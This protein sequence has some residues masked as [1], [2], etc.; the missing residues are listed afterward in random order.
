M[1]GPELITNG[2]FVG[3]ADGWDL[4]DG[5]TYN[6]NDV[7]VADGDYSHNFGLIEQEIAATTLNYYWVS[8]DIICES[9]E[10]PAEGRIKVQ[11]GESNTFKYQCTHSRTITLAIQAIIPDMET[12]S[13][14]IAGDAVIIGLSITN[15][16][17]KSVEFSDLLLGPDLITN[18]GFVGNADN[19]ILPAPWS[20][21]DN[22]VVYVQGP[23]EDDGLQQNI[24]FDND[25][26][27]YLAKMDVGGTAGFISVQIEDGI[28]MGEIAAGTVPGYI[29]AQS[30][31]DTPDG[32]VHIYTNGSSM[33]YFNGT[34]TNVSLKKILGLVTTVTQFPNTVYFSADGNE[35]HYVHFLDANGDHVEDTIVATEDGGDIFSCVLVMGSD[36][37]AR[38]V[39]TSTGDGA[40][41]LFV[42]ICTN[43]SGSEGTNIQLDSNLSLFEFSIVLDADDNIYIV[44]NDYES[45]NIKLARCD[46]D[47]SNVQISTIT[48]FTLGT[49]FGLALSA[50][51]GFLR[52]AYGDTTPTSPSTAGYYLKCTNVGATTFSKNNISDLGLAN[53]IYY[54]D[55]VLADDDTARIIYANSSDSGAQQGINYV[56]CTSTDGSSYD[57]SSIFSLHG[58]NSG[59]VSIVL[60][61][62]GLPRLAY[63]ILDA[64]SFH[65]IVYAEFSV[66]DVS[67]FTTINLE[68]NVNVS[69][70]NY[71]SMCIGGD[72]VIGI[73]YLTNDA[74]SLRFARIVDP[75][76][77]TYTT[78]LTPSPT[79]SFG[80]TNQKWIAQALTIIPPPPLDPEGFYYGTDDTIYKYG[81]KSLS[82]ELI[83]NGNFVTNADGW[84]V[85]DGDN[86]EHPLPHEG[87]EYDGDNNTVVHE[88]G[89]GFGSSLSQNL[90][91]VIQKATYQIS[92]DIGGTAGSIDVQLG[93]QNG[94][95]FNF[96]TSPNFYLIVDGATPDN[97]L[98]LTP[99]TDF[100]GTINNV[101]VKR[102]L[103]PQAYM[104]QVVT[105]EPL[106]V[107]TTYQIKFD[108]SSNADVAADTVLYAGFSALADLEAQTTILELP[109]SVYD[110][111]NIG[112]SKIGSFVSQLT[113]EEGQD[114][115]FVTTV[116]SDIG[117]V[118]F[119]NFSLKQIL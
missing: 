54:F 95:T 91:T 6:D 3:N 37:F 34:L 33:P 81:S 30:L 12:A 71:V 57:T 24:T 14:V 51:D 56:K 23:G 43:D 42:R 117:D 74:A 88:P 39:Y 44:Y 50:A 72:D 35:L 9:G 78:F 8:F 17:V 68:T 77:I 115:F 73:A 107:G 62:D 118:T 15:V 26:A 79:M 5:V 66:D 21:G 58:S 13:L 96:N 119:D 11:I 103:L 65:D 87:W 46:A 52:I 70:G 111:V 94:G 86:I 100:D 85:N 41:S 48:T 112:P 4:G 109:N 53:G 98:D 93:G 31:F 2:G 27:Q 38:I 40:D 101:S 99:T 28:D 105:V 22:N 47:G 45:N 7:L 106:K 64:D 92:F 16:S 59:Q 82:D 10:D 32:T 89:G 69:D 49:T 20:Y 55:M 29:V 114:T 75:D 116:L 97:I 102:V 25:E 113:V 84:F 1:L 110:S 90:G 18:G 61:S 76:D 83:V 104:Y 19:W 36:G 108:Y 67:S 63:G 60:T 80:D